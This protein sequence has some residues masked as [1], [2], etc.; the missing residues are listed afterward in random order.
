VDRI[1]GILLLT[2][3]LCSCSSVPTS[4][5]YHQFYAHLQPRIRSFTQPSEISRY[6]IVFLV[7]ARHLDYTDNYS[8]C[9]TVAKHPSDGSKNGDVGHA[10]I[11]LQ[12]EVDGQTVFIEGGHTGETGCYQAPYFDGIMN[13]LDYGY[14]T[15]T[16]EQLLS[17]RYEPNP[18][19]YLWETQQDGFFQWGAGNHRPSFAARI[20]LSQE[21]FLHVLAF[22]ENYGYAEYALT[23]NQCSSFMA[24]VAAIAELDLESEV[25]MQIASHVQVGGRCLRLWEDPCYAELTIAT[26]DVL[27]K[28]LMD[29][30]EGGHATDAMEWYSRTHP[31]TF[32]SSFCKWKKDLLL[33]PKRLMR[34]Q[35]L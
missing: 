24:Q 25:T 15:P 13:Y 18:V 10:W 35:Q 8:F 2:W 12:G 5:A 6:F 28:S 9:K 29:A 11:Y 23:G 22:L 31:C 19:K 3:I 30:V 34:Y 1:I 17:P 32:S 26:P 16:S 7:D 21:Q 33:F 14:A 4:E 27:E 20:D